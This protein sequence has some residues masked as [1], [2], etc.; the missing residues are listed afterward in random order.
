MWLGYPAQLFGQTLV[1]PMD[2]FF[3]T[4][5]KPW[6][7]HVGRPSLLTGRTLE[8]R[9]FSE[10]GILPP[11]YKVEMCLGFWSSD[12]GPQFLP[13]SPTNY[14]ASH[15][16]DLLAFGTACVNLIKSISALTYTRVLSVLFLWRNLASWLTHLLKE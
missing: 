10:E 13:E 4:C 6:N 9:Q 1:V 8:Q 15:S 11:T 3:S 14:I 2:V 12:S 7:H 5:N 16:S